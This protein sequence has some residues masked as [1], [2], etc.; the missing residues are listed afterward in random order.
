M[1]V[2]AQETALSGT[3][4]D[5]TDAVLPGVTVTALHVESGNTFTGVTDARGT[6]Q[7]N[8]LRAGV[9]KLT[10]ELQ[11]FAS[12]VRDGLVLAV[13]QH[14][15]LDFKMGVTALSETVT[16]SGSAPLIDTTQSKVSGNIDPRQIQDLPLN[17]RNWMDLTLLSP[18]SR[19]NSVS[20]TALTGPSN[21]QISS[22]GSPFG[23]TG[24]FQLNVD[25]QQVTNQLACTSWGQAKFS[26]DAIQEFEM[27]TSRF[28]AAQGRST[29]VQ[30]NAVTKAGT[31]RFSGTGAGYFRSDKFNAPDF[32]AHKVLPYSDQQGSVTFGGPIRKD[33]LHFFGYWDGERNPNSY[34]F[35]SSYPSFNNVPG[36]TNVLSTDNKWGGRGDYQISTN[37]HLM[38]RANGFYDDIPGASNTAGALLHPSRSTTSTRKSYGGLATLTHVFGPR[39]FNE[40]RV[41]YT[42][43]ISGDFTTAG[44]SPQ[45]SLTGGYVIGN[46]TFQ[47][48][49]LTYRAPSFRDDFTY[50]F[51]KHQVKFGGEFLYYYNS[52]FWPSNKYGALNATN[53]AAPA[54]LETLFPV[55]NDPS[56]WNL[57]GLA[58]QTISWT[59][60]V[61]N[62]DYYIFDPMHV[63][64]TWLQDDWRV[65]SHVTA[66]LGVRWDVQLGGLGESLDFPPFHS[67]RGHELHDVS[68]RLG[69]AWQVK[70]TTVIRGGW[71]MYYQG[72]SDQPSQ[73]ALLD[74]HTVSMTIFNDGRP[75]FPLNP[76]NGPIP[77]YDQALALAG[78][79]ST[80]GI[81]LSQFA[82]VPLTYQASIG[83]EQQLVSDMSFKV[84]FVG[85]NDLYGRTTRNINLTYNPATGVNYP[86]TD[87]A[88]RAYPGWSIVSMEFNDSNSHYRGLEAGFVKRMSHHWQASASYTLQYIYQQEIVPLNPGCQYPATAPGVCN[89]PLTLAPDLPQGNWYLTGAQKNRV[90]LNGIWQAPFGFQLGGIYLYGDNGYSTTTPG[91]D[92]RQANTTA[93][94]LNTD[95][96]IIPRNNFKNDPTSKVDVRIQRGFKLTPTKRID[97]SAEAF[98]LFNH[99]TY[100]FVT[101]QASR[102]FGGISTANLS[103]T[104][105]LGVRVAF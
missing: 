6:Y 71:G 29:G 52:I 75:D 40:V 1:A 2:R 26:N 54:N 5:S 15:I 59:Q 33:K 12:Q 36:F 24:A 56:T 45:I 80:S 86:F 102:S 18:G 51:D 14:P 16:V 66:N 20:G 87:P 101:N 17:G 73:H 85:T 97:F 82:K 28:D 19:V 93:G 41:G 98:N 22:A 11:G 42:T 74:P 57:N 43:N 69:L 3:V 78:T 49:Y 61:S 96:T 67:P 25:G 64:G 103:R 39:A 68:P 62:N 50:H 55:W 99:S 23:N 77:S 7:I 60:S 81:L 83:I 21:N 32:I 13:G 38:V 63:F 44:P 58:K 72:Q 70:P 10:V 53:G 104:V 90:V 47:P 94:R 31:N 48:L 100:A 95:G 105:Q 88:H 91:V 34:T 92:V 9:Y 76:F 30:V 79:R 37:T 8:G 46:L 89:V 65:T 4:M 84:D 27:V 35:T